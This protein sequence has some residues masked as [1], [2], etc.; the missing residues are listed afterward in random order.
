MPNILR[1][2]PNL[3]LLAAVDDVVAPVAP[4]P[5]TDP[6]MLMFK[7]A[8]SVVAAAVPPAVGGSGDTRPPGTSTASPPEAEGEA[9]MVVMV[10]VVVME[11]TLLGCGCCW[12]C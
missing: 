7:L 4:V 3:L 5:A 10:P 8:A 2:D 11:F 9:V 6:S 12:G 1:I